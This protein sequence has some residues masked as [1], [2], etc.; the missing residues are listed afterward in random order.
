MPVK[1]VRRPGYDWFDGRI[2]GL[3]KKEKQ[4]LE[5]ELQLTPGD[6]DISLD[7][8][9]L[10]DTGILLNFTFDD[11]KDASLI[12]YIYKGQSY[13]GIQSSQSANLLQFQTS[14]GTTLYLI[15]FDT[16]LNYEVETIFL[17]IPDDLDDYVSTNIYETDI[18][19]LEQN[20]PTDIQYDENGFKLM[21]D[22][23]EISGQTNKVKLKTVNS[24]S[25]V[26]EGNI[27]ISGTQGPQGPQGNPGEDGKDALVCVSTFTA[28][29]PTTGTTL[30]AVTGDFNRTPALDETFNIVVNDIEGGKTYFGIANISNISGNNITVEIDNVLNITGLQGP[31]GDKGD[32]GAQGPQGIQG[33]QGP[34]G[35]DGTQVLEQEVLQVNGIE[36]IPVGSSITTEIL[37]LPQNA[38]VK[39]IKPSVEGV[40]VGF[41]YW[42]STMW[43][44]TLYNMS[45]SS[46]SDLTLDITYDTVS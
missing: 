3:T 26:G 38:I 46:V 17:T 10:N 28:S 42:D 13:T 18:A 32:T 20:I 4:I 19:A 14:I 45:Q 30:N 16:S 43:K 7:L 12:N 31:K 35:Q 27:D 11:L 5:K 40:L 33:I 25:L 8:G 23:Q 24:Q 6:L 36:S 21:H 44:I 41:P 39:S 2:T 22:N 37:S 15:S 29:S 1:N 9:V 34:A